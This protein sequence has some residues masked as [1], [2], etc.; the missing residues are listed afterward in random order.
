[1]IFK[2]AQ[3]D[4][5]LKSP[6]NNLKCVVIYGNNEGLVSE[7]VK[8]FTRVISPEVNDPFQ[9]AYLSADDINSDVGILFGEYGSRSLMGGRR[10]IVIRDG[11]NNLTKN[12]K[13]LFDEVNSDTLIIIYSDSLNKKSSLVKMAEDSDDM[14]AIACYE[15]RDEDIYNTA[16]NVFL[17]NKITISGE[18]LQLLCSRLSNDRKCNLGE[19]DK[20]ITYIG[21]RKN[22]VPEDVFKIISDTSSSSTDDVCFFTASGDNEKSQKAFNRLIK[23]NVEP[24]SIV[25][26]LSYHFEKILNCYALMEKGQSLDSA[27]S[28]VV[29]I[30]YRKPSFKTQVSI[31]NRDKALYVL[32]IIYN[33]ERSCKTTNMPSEEIV[34]YTLMQIASA[35]NRLKR[36]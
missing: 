10:V 30:F 26:A 7:Y 16:K 27:V 6:D 13:K 15:D 22:I 12:L 14:A 5:F 2:Q 17:E 20:L 24:I 23:E 34:S 3:I 4:K 29:P 33:C 9:V 28:A 1:M 32:D 8:S 11:D 35:A 36:N 21:D 31:W 19:I 25:R 18:A